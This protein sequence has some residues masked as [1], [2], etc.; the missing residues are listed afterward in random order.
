MTAKEKKARSTLKW[1]ILSY[2][3]LIKV[4][5]VLNFFLARSEATHKMYTHSHTGR[6]ISVPE[7]GAKSY[8]RRFLKDLME[9]VGVTKQEFIFAYHTR[10]A[11]PAC[12][13][14]SK[15]LAPMRKFV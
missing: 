12:F 2:E 4:L 6:T 9:Q 14:L 1:P 15:V 10:K 8:N 13:I 3:E 7:H 5:R 11:R